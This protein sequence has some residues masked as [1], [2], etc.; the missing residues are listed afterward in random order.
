MKKLLLSIIIGLS[1]ITANAAEIV[2]GVQE[3]VQRATSEKKLVGVLYTIVSDPRSTAYIKTIES[4]EKTDKDIV[5]LVAP[6]E[7]PELMSFFS[8]LANAL[9]LTAIPV[10]I[11][12]K[13]GEM[14][15]QVTG[16]T[17][18]EKELAKAIDQMKS[19]I[20]KD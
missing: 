1:S 13:E 10:I 15:G 16:I 5:L 14:I 8:S 18:S 17:S 12:S 19:S 2:T 20:K 4:Y 9:R 3:L 6:I 7:N 11:F